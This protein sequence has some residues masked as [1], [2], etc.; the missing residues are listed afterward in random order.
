MRIYGDLMSKARVTFFSDLNILLG[1]FADLS[2]RI[3]K[4]VDTYSI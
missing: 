2:M 4:I 1:P 3:Q